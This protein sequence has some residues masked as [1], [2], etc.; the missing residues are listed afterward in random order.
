MK[1]LFFLLSIVGAASKYGHHEVDVSEMF[2]FTRFNLLFK[3]NFLLLS[4]PNVDSSHWSNLIQMRTE[5][6]CVYP[7]S[8]FGL[9]IDFEKR[10]SMSITASFEALWNCPRED[11]YDFASFFK[12]TYEASEIHERHTFEAR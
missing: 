1:P 10:T 7:S 6:Y 3:L 5:S 8:T 12:R 11:N 9:V 4:R 2:Q